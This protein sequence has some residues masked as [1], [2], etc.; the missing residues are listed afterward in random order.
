VAEGDGLLN[1]QTPNSSGEFQKTYGHGVNHLSPDL[2]LNVTNHPELAQLIKTWP[3]LPEA[4]R[5]GI[6]AMVNASA[7]R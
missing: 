6:V 4:L 3:T 1:R 5:A 2:S 7:K